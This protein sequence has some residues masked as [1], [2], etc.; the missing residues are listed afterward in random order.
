[1]AYLSIEQLN[2]MGFK[3]LGEN[4]KISDKA[5][6]YN[7]DQIEIGD[8]SRIDDFCVL[9]G[10]IVIGKF[11]HIAPF[12][13][14]AGG[15]KGIYIDDFSGISYSCSIFSQS[16]DYSGMWLTSPLIP[17]RFKLEY[18]A[19]VNIGRHVIVGTKSVIFPGVTC[20]E[21]SSIGAMSL[22]TKNTDPWGIY[23]G[24]PAKRIK[25]RKRE[26]LRLEQQFWEEYA[27]GD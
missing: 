9:S 3:S 23:I 19:T 17:P 5:S 6:I 12:N 27:H 2:T 14:L 26:M 15:E 7:A 24:I 13:L 18:K 10:K 8:H 4:I 25:E 20:A 21:G 22:V 1:M 11:V 16:D